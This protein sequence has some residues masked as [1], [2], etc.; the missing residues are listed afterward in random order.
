MFATATV[1]EI[2][3]RVTRNRFKLIIPIPQPRLLY[4]LRKCL[5]DVDQATGQLTFIDFDPLGRSDEDAYVRIDPWGRIRLLIYPTGNTP[6]APAAIRDQDLP[7]DTAERLSAFDGDSPEESDSEL[8]RES[9]R[10]NSNVVANLRLRIDRQRATLEEIT[11]STGIPE[12]RLAEILNGEA[13]A[14]VDEVCRLAEFFGT[15]AE[16]L[17]APPRDERAQGWN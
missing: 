4:R 6:S 12:F 3:N 17:L 5:T 16:A 11:E 7:G 15:T 13:S 8:P 1:V 14:D 10:L 2:D 9:G